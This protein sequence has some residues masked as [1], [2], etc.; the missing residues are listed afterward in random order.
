MKKSQQLG[1]TQW[2]GVVGCNLGR[3]ARDGIVVAVDDDDDDD[4]DDGA[5]AVDREPSRAEDPVKDPDRSHSLS[6]WFAEG[7]GAGIPHDDEV[8][9]SGTCGQVD[10][11]SSS[12]SSS[13]VTELEVKDR[14][15]TS[16][17]PL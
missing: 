9:D 2:I 1:T 16:L 6:L 12:S 7:A 10:W 5:G 17:C 4:D 11:F 15:C 8:S 14:C 3:R 13:V